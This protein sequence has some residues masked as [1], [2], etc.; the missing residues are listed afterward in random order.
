MAKSKQIELQNK[1]VKHLESY[2]VLC[3]IMD[4]NL[5]QLH[6]VQIKKISKQL[7]VKL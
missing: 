7:G 2:Q 6:L 1:L 3:D 4:Y 5:A